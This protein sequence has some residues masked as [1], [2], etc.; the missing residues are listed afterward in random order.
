MTAAQLLNQLTIQGF[1]LKLKGENIEVSGG[2]LTDEQRQAMR[3]HKPALC[4]LL[5]P[6]TDSYEAAER[7]AIQQEHEATIEDC[8]FP[9]FDGVRHGMSIGY[10]ENGVKRSK[11]RYEQGRENGTVT[12]WYDNG[13][14]EYEVFFVAGVKQGIEKWWYD[15][16]VQRIEIRY[17]DGVEHGQVSAWDRDG[18]LLAQ[19]RYEHGSLIER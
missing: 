11:V 7:E 1:I 6:E 12:L 17:R 15:N 8:E 5:Q 2:T 3:E 16:G 13:R 19:K 9:S 4:G 10:H 14:R 18:R